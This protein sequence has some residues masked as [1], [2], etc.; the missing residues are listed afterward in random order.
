[1]K[2]KASELL[3][4]SEQPFYKACALV[5]EME[6]VLQNLVDLKDYKDENGKDKYY[7]EQQPIA[8]AKARILL[9]V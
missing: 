6:I 4:E 5:K 7:L 1:M 8:W 3:E 2:K 9:G